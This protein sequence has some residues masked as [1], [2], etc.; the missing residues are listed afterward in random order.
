MMYVYKRKGRV[1]QKVGTGFCI[2]SQ[3]VG[4]KKGSN[5]NKGKDV[6]T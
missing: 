2:P 3:V 4:M 5:N 6:L 1:E